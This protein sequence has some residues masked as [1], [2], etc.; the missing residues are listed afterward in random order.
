MYEKLLK[1]ILNKPG[2]SKTDSLLLILE[3]SFDKPL[4]IK[5][6]LKIGE[7]CGLRTSSFSK[8]PSFLLMRSNGKAIRTPKGWELTISGHQYI[9]EKYGIGLDK[10]QGKVSLNLRT[11]LLKISNQDVSNFV[12]EAIIAYENHLFRSAVVLSWIGA[13][14]ILYD[15]IIA[16]KLQDFN[17]EALKRNMKW[18]IA[19]TSDDLSL[20]K[21]S[22]FLEI[23][24]SISVLGKNV[25][26]ELKLCLDLRNGC[27]HPNSLTIAEH[28]VASHIEMLILNVFSKFV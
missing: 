21:E 8:N 11:H 27:G 22:D 13:M 12:E 24:V 10:I 7:N 2:I 26:N 9:T 18:K 19:Q 28:R 6:I 4:S 1:D 14:A 25:K 16:N 3:S 15:Y 20:M 23:L 5:E 17:T